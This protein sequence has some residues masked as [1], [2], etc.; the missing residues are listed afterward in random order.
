M[1]QEARRLAVL[2]D[3]ENAR[4][5]ILSE[6]LAEIPK[7]GSA[8]LKRHRPEDSGCCSIMR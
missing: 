2:I 3:A 4:L 8:R 6:L 1:D 7:V 5:A